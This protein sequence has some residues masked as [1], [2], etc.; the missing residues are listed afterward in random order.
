MEGN[1]EKI[2]NDSSPE[3]PKPESKRRGRQRKYATLQERIDANAKKQC[4]QKRELT[5]IKHLLIKNGHQNQYELIAKLQTQAFDTAY[6]YKILSEI[7]NYE[8][9][10]D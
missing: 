1:C 3:E 7:D 10:L 9:S 2:N 8:V 6:I 4:E 5:K